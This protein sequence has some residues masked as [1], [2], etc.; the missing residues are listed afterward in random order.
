MET[1]K[2]TVDVAISWELQTLADAIGNCLELNDEFIRRYCGDRVGAQLLRIPESDREYI[3]QSHLGDG[4]A[5]GGFYSL[6]DDS[7]IL[8]VGEIEY[9]F[10][11]SPEDTFDDP[12]DWTIKGNLAY[13]TLDA[14]EF[15]VDVA[16]LETEIDEFL[17]GEMPDE[18]V[19]A[20][21]ECALWSSTDF[22]GNPLDDSATVDDISRETMQ[23]M[24]TDCAAFWNRNGWILRHNVGRA[25]HDFWLTRNR[26]G[27][28][29][30]DGDWKIDG[31]DF[32]KRLTDDCRPYG[33]VDLYFG[34][35]GK[36]YG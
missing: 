25:G 23:Q 8:P 21:A 24:E 34:D 22:D 14:A 4:R 20:Y 18:F 32:G 31:A 15:P 12:S 13:A 5:V 3:L 35:D 30:W 7:I 2:I 33:G 9:Q 29:F 6:D 28:G 10:D 26:H 1:Q 11:G 27:A 19:S 36:I 16:A 17:S